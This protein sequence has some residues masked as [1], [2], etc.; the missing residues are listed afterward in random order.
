MDKTGTNL[1]L[2]FR[3]KVRKA[4]VRRFIVISESAIIAVL[5]L[6]V[7]AADAVA[8]WFLVARR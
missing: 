1:S 4:L 8:A 3:Q 2:V 6:T 5:I 7:L